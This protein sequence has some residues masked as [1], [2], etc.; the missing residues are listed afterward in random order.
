MNPKYFLLVLLTIILFAPS[1]DV[2]L[3]FAQ[4]QDSIR[5]F[6]DYRRTDPNNFPPIGKYAQPKEQVFPLGWNKGTLGKVNAGT[7]VWTE[8]NPLVPRVNYIGLHFVNKDTGWA[9]GGSG[10]IIKTTSGGVDWTISETPVTNLLLKIHSYNG[11]VVIVTGYDGIILRSSDSGETFELIPSGV[12]NGIDLWGVQMLNDTLGWVCGTN[13]TLLRTTDSG[14]S[15]QPFTPGL[16]DHYWAIDFINENYG[17]ISCGGGK[18]LKTTDGGDSWTQ[19]QAGDTR[20]LFTIDII[21]SQH[22]AAAGVFGKNVYS[23]DGGVNWTMNTDVVVFSAVNWINFINQDT[24]YCV[25]DVYNIAKT[26]NRGQTWFN[27]NPTFTISEWHIQLLEDGTGFACGE[28]IGG[29]YALNVVKRTNGLDNWNRIFLNTNWSDVFFIDETK[30]FA[31][32]SSVIYGGLYKTEDGGLTYQKIENAPNGNDIFF[33]DSMTGFIAGTHKST[34]GGES[35][36]ATNGG[37]TKVFFLDDQVGWSIGG[38]TILKTTDKGEQWITQLTLPADNFTSIFFIDTLNGWATS[39]YIWQTT[40][41][42]ISWIQRT[43]IPVFFSDEIYFINS[44]GF[45]IEFLE[46]YKTTNSGNNWFTQLNSQY[47]IRSFGWLSASHGFIIGDGVYETIDNG[48]TWDEI[49]ELRNIGLRKLHSPKIYVGYAVGYT[50]L[51]YKY[52]D[53]TIVPVE[54]TSFYSKANNN[55]VILKWSTATEINNLGFEVLRSSDNQNWNSLVFI[56]GNGTTI[57]THNYQFTDRIENSGIYSYKLKQIDYDGS[58]N[59]SQIIEVRIANPFTFKLYQNYPNPFNPVTNITYQLP[60]KTN[61]TIKVFNVLGSE[62]AT[63]VNEE[64]DAGIHTLTFNA[65]NLNSGVYIYHLKTDNYVNA[66]K[67]ILLK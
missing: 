53:T 33:L 16:N 25:R 47:I 24:G 34:D 31:I 60:Q 23:S 17:M 55:T 35:W 52:I 67:M 59:L 26:T 20:A 11:Q 58:F 27:P 43:D 64:K 54:L 63:L 10:A 46:L 3:C 7:G 29:N 42:G 2:L 40:D 15:W 14:L 8:L 51:V 45:V 19:T 65:E 32:S 38:N 41:G 9:C 37:G 22:I 4:E 50:G 6:I 30:G 57:Q 39:R 13:W 28:E 62:I 1:A 21:D 56:K 61:V 12:G 48:N 66:K 36:Y 5:E 18:V 44:L 49:L